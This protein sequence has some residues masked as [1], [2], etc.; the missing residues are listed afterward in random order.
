[1]AKKMERLEAS[2][3]FRPFKFRIQAF[4]NAFHESL[5]QHGLTEDILPLR[6][7]K[8]YL[9][10]H[11]YIA[12]FNADGKKQK[13]KGNHVWNIEARKLPESMS[14]NGE[15]T[16][17][18]GAVG[19]SLPA[20]PT[21]RWEFRE[22]KSRIAGEVIKYARVGFLYLY[23]PKIWDVL[24]SC[25]EAQYHSPELPAWLEWHNQKELRGTPGRSDKSCDITVVAEYEREGEHCR[26]EMTFR[27]TVSDPEQEGSMES[28]EDEDE[29]QDDVDE[30][31]SSNEDED[32]LYSRSQKIDKETTSVTT[33]TSISTSYNSTTS[34]CDSDVLTKQARKRPAAG[35][36]EQSTKKPRVHLSM[37]C[38]GVLD[39]HMNNA[40]ITDFLT[41]HLHRRINKLLSV[42]MDKARTT[43]HWDGSPSTQKS[44]ERRRRQDALDKKLAKLQ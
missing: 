40:I 18:T 30:G 15:G 1:M 5:T 9:W 34:P 35:Y 42:H 33:T 20:D 25:P 14:C 27:L 7:V 23:T 8:L 29:E 28:T 2:T 31:E 26:L 10:K 6:K 38:T 32:G 44:A 21:D 41:V 36:E 39:A 37:I 43:L 22:Y 12:R 19:L 24:V 17:S 16:T 13:S 11:K 3:E 4:T